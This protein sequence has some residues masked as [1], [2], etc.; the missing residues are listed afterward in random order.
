MAELP[1]DGPTAESAFLLSISKMGCKF[2]QHKSKFYHWT[3]LIFMSFL[4]VGCFPL[5]RI[6]KKTVG[7]LGPEYPKE[8]IVIVKGSRHRFFIPFNIYISSTAKIDRVDNQRYA[9]G[10]DEVRIPSGPHE[11]VIIIEKRTWVLGSISDPEGVGGVRLLHFELDTEAGH[12]YK[13][14]IPL[15]WRKNSIIKIIDEATKEIVGSQVVN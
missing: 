12:K 7:G 14:D 8:Q 11:V 4:L 15:Y 1:K 2:K 6:V 3:I 13:V 9:Y 5:P 10:A